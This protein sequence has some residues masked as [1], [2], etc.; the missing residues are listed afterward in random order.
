MFNIQQNFSL[1]ETEQIEKNPVKT[2]FQPDM[3]I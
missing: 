2:F 1:W 3:C